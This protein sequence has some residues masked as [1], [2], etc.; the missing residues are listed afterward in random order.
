MH[1]GE[2]IELVVRRD[3]ISIS[4]LSRKL[5]VSRKSIYNWFKKEN[6]SLDVIN[7]IGEVLN[8]DFT[9]EL[10]EKYEE[11]NVELKKLR[12]DSDTIDG[13][14]P[15]VAH[16]WKTKYI[17]LLESYTGLLIKNRS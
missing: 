14:D 6:L 2:I 17:N 12:Q 15:N 8:H 10:P 9:T 11:L 1:N 5:K 7:R 13:F 16:Y 4:E 3:K